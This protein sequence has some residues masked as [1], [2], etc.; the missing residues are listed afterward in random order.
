M[1]EP[2]KRLAFLI[3]LCLAVLATVLV[4]GSF[5]ALYHFLSPPPYETSFALRPTGEVAAQ[6][7]TLPSRP[8]PAQ[9]SLMA[10]VLRPFV[11]VMVW[12]LATH[13]VFLAIILGMFGFW[14]YALVTALSREQGTDRLTWTLVILFANV[15]GAIIYLVMR[16]EPEEEVTDRLIRPPASRVPDRS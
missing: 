10:E 11:A 15:V 6:S 1:R 14:I 2:A 8:A 5:A 12:A 13:A 9:Q 16:R 7:A 4:F 3:P